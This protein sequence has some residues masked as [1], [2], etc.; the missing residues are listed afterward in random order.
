MLGKVTTLLMSLITP[1]SEEVQ[2]ELES[3]W[4]KHHLAAD[5][6]SI[7]ADSA[8]LAQIIAQ[9]G[10]PKVSSVGEQAS[11]GA[12]WVLRHSPLGLQAQALPLLKKRVSQGEVQPSL[13][14]ELEDRLR[15]ANGHKQIYGTQ[16]QID[17]Q[18]GKSIPFPVESPES[19]DALRT[20]YGMDSLQDYLSKFNLESAQG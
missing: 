2:R 6:Q 11:L 16:L 1:Q 5:K 12:Y 10:W 13:V 14:A 8:R 18:T 9:Q 7:A 19:V 4:S 20:S 15:L 17:A 3:M